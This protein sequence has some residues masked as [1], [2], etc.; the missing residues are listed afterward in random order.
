MPI[1]WIGIT[2]AGAPDLSGASFHER[3]DP[4]LAQLHLW[5][6]RSL[7]RRGFV[8]FIGATAAL[9]LVP[10][11]TVLGTPILWG[12]LPFML[13]TLGL[14]WALLEKSYRDGEILEELTLWSDH[15]RLL[16]RGRRQPLAEWQANPYWVSVHLHKSG[17]P[18]ENY[19]TLKGAG[20]EVEI[21]AFL[22]Q[23]ERDVLYPQLTE[24][25]RQ[26][27]LTGRPA[28]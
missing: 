22:S 15:V 4:P 3:G 16:R 21:G 18:V 27:A 2:D 9:I 12:L 17:G 24:V 20:R 8:F 25:F 7:P 5:P 14:L 13:G 23:E 28:G 10:L 6:N 11:L 1:E 19:L 26:L